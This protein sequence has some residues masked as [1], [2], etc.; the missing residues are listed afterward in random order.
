MNMLYRLALSQPRLFCLVVF[1]GVAVAGIESFGISFFLPLLSNG[2]NSVELNIPL[3]GNIA[4]YFD[5]LGANDRIQFVALALISTAILRGL[6]VYLQKL[7]SEF[8][9]TAV[10]FD[11]R[12]DIFNQVLDVSPEF[13]EKTSVGEHTTKIMSSAPIVGSVVLQS[14]VA[15]S[16]V[17]QAVVFT[18][19]LLLLS[20]PLTLSALFVISITF[21][22]IKVKFKKKLSVLSRELHSHQIHLNQSAMEMVSSLRFIHLAGLKGVVSKQATDQSSGYLKFCRKSRALLAMVDPLFSTSIALVIGGVLFAITFISTEDPQSYVPITLLFMFVLFRLS[23]PVMNIV[24]SRAFIEAYWHYVTEAMNFL[25]PTDK[26]YLQDGYQEAPGDF[27][28]INLKD[29]SFKYEGAERDA[30]KHISLSIPAN[31]VTALVGGSGSGKSTLLG[32]VGRL[33]DPQEGQVL[34]GDVELSKLKLA[35]WRKQLFVVTQETY[36]FFGTIRENLLMAKPGA[37]EQELEDA[38]RDAAAD[39]FIRDM[40]DGLDTLIGDRGVKLSGGQRQRLSLAR[41]LLAKPKLLMLDEATSQLDSETEKFIQESI[42]RLKG[43]MTLL[44]VAHRLSTIK[45]ADKIYALQ[46]G[47]VVESGDHASL[48][49]TGGYYRR[50]VNMQSN[51]EVND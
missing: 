50:L 2:D 34:V 14:S 9:Q 19:V 15:V 6:F 13:I 32:V 33:Y 35:S 46:D 24:T 43:K 7:S 4:S 41:A 23:T 44:I 25:D 28:S 12:R 16:A 45:E 37:S 10:E 17:L 5:G 29:V 22:L 49:S 42:Q 27:H 8:L 11:L 1:L 18:S 51:G 47:A 20:V 21:L 3:I 26:P 30:L 48:M 36:L 39:T 31:K 40:P 38:I